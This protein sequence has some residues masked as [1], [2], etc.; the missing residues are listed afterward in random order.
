MILL[1]LLFLPINSINSQTQSGCVLP[2]N[3]LGE[4]YSYEN[5]YETFTNIYNTGILKRKQYSREAGAGA[6]GDSSSTLKLQSDEQGYCVSL[7]KHSVPGIH[8]SKVHWKLHY[9][10]TGGAIKDCNQCIE[11]YNRTRSVIEIRRSSCNNN[12]NKNFTELC[13]EIAPTSSF[14]TLF[15]RTYD[16]QECRGTIYGTYQFRYEFREGGQGNCDNA[17]SKITSCPDP[18][19]PF[20]TVNQRFTMRYASCKNLVSSIDAEPLYDCLGNWVDEN[21]NIFTAIANQRIATERS[22]DK[23]RCMLTRKDQPRWFTK[24]LYASCQALY[25]P[26]DGPEKV[27][28]TPVVPREVESKCFFPQNFSG[29]WINT[30]NINAKIIINNTHIYEAARVDNRGWLR[31]TYYVCQQAGRN[32]YLVRSVT[33][34]EC[35]DYFI[36]LD[37]KPRHQNILQYRKSKSFMARIYDDSKKRDPFYEVCAWTSFGGDSVWKYNTYAL[38]PPAPSECPFTGIFRFK[39]IGQDSSK[40]HTR[41][42][43]GYT[44]LP[45][46]G[47]WF[48]KCLPEFLESQWS[49]CGAQTKTMNVDAEYCRGMDP[50]GTPVRQYEM[51][52]Y[53]YQCAGHWR[54]NARSYMVTYDRDEPFHQ[55]RC[56]IYERIDLFTIY[57]S[58]SISSQCGPN[59]TS[60]SYLPEEGADLHLILT[61]NERIH[62]DCPIRY[63]DGDR[64]SVV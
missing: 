54:E 24:S 27:I 10:A 55:F 49:V 61:E 41:I 9:R 8:P 63:D 38:Y 32:Q 56:W 44:P 6:Q 62:D 46:D 4:F 59:Q 22:Y 11:I 47:G 13:N 60:H 5:G 14:L 7:A 57:L 50:N 42:R 53:V 39:Q 64:K 31:E 33:K 36:C 51:Y 18:G 15:N 3:V 28:I 26:T 48:I 17:A 37:F 43:G 23:F 12:Q 40:I 21:G 34:G 16:A 20:Q 35:F 2:D 19:S 45:R 29:E 52:D 30:A 25:S 58:R 1:I